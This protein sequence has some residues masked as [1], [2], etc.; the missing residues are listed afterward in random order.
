MET[1]YPDSDLYRYA[2]LLTGPER[3]EILRLRAMLTE[4]LP[5]EVIDNHWDRAAFPADA[6]EPIARGGFLAPE[7]FG[8]E[9]ERWMY[10]GFRSFELARHDASLATWFNGQAAL[11]RTNIEVG[12]SPEQVARWQPDV[13]DFTARGVFAMTEPDHGSD[14]AG[15]LATTARRD[16]DDWVIDGAKRW[17]GSAA[18]A[19]HICVIAREPDRGPVRAFVVP[20]AADGVTLTTIERKTSLRIVNNAVIELDSVRVPDEL[21]LARV[22]SFADVGEMLRRMRAC[23]AWHAAGVQA[24]AFEAARRYVLAREQFGRP[25]GGFQLVQEKLARMLG[26]LTSTL[27]IVV[28]LSQ[29]QDEGVFDEVESSL[30]KRQTCLHMRETV[31]LAREVCG[32]NGITL[33]S[34][35]ARFHADAEGIYTYEGTDDINAL[36]VGRAITGLSAFTR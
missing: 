36:V 13:L 29:R 6:V 8:A 2:D 21:R 7:A 12:G 17:I 9:P 34:G 27:G 20:R 19:D 18:F 35:V 11:F 14:V 16:G 33:D 24:G 3:A 4:H 5:A 1:L 26:N 22:E 30:A 23:V 28:R 15:G 25:I 32:G 31:A 10:Q